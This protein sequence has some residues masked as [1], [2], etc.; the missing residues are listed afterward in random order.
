MKEAM[1][2]MRILFKFLKVLKPPFRTSL[3]N[4][5]FCSK[6]EEVRNFWSEN[7][8]IMHVSNSKGLTGHSQYWERKQLRLRKPKSCFV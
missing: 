1:M 5:G 6:T 8:F 4:G 2:I 3:R 7:G